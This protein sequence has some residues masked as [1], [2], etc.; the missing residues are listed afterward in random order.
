[1]TCHKA[2]RKWKSEDVKVVLPDSLAGGT[3]QRL[4]TM[5]TDDEDGRSRAGG[6]LLRRLGRS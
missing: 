1:M 6:S 5:Q 3:G 4:R 2:V